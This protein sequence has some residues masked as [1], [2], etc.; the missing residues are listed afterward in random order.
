MCI[1]LHNMVMMA[2]ARS[3]LGKNIRLISYMFY[4]NLIISY[5]QMSEF[6]HFNDTLDTKGQHTVNMIKELRHSLHERFD[7]IGFNNDELNDEF[8]LLGCD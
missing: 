5:I 3:L 8:F 4:I 2:N 1:F 7:I 6:V